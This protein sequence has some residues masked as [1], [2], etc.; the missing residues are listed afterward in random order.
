MDRSSRGLFHWETLPAMIRTLL[1]TVPL[2]PE[3]IGEPY[4]LPNDQ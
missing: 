2:D 4:L 3:S 1:A